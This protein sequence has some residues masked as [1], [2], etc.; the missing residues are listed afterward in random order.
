M[1]SLWSRKRKQQHL[2]PF[3]SNL[4]VAAKKYYFLNLGNV[5]KTVYWIIQPWLC[6]AFAR[7]AWEVMAKCKLMTVSSV[8]WLAVVRNLLKSV[9]IYWMWHLLYLA[10]TFDLS[11]HNTGYTFS[12]WI[13]GK[14]KKKVFIKDVP[15]QFWILSFLLGFLHWFDLQ[16]VNFCFLSLPFPSEALIACRQQKGFFF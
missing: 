11:P 16:F 7:G 15:F 6:F 8:Q 1:K 3:Q 10:L 4:L 5:V 14:E 2:K 12:L 13:M 9:S